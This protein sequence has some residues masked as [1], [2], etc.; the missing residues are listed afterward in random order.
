G[1]PRNPSIWRVSRPGPTSAD[2]RLVTLPEQTGARL[3]GGFGV[4]RLSVA[5]IGGKVLAG[6]GLELVDLVRRVVA[7][8]G[9]ALVL[10]VGRGVAPALG[11]GL[12]APALGEVAQQLSGQGGG[13]AGHPGPG[14]AQGLLGLRRVG[15]RRGQQGR[16]QPAVLLAG[17]VDQPAG[18]AGVGGAG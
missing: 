17:G 1:W 7:C 10:A 2:A 4:A 6:G 3:G 13:L 5:Q 18:V 8:G 15:Q 14:A 12:A 16:R 9:L 11:P